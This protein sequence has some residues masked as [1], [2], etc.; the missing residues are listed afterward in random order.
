MRRIPLSR[1]LFALVDEEDYPALSKFNWYAQKS[2]NCFVAARSA[3]RPDRGLIYMH[4]EILKAPPEL[5]VDHRNGDG[6][7]NQRENLRLKTV[8]GN[9]QAF[10]RKAKGTTSRFRG[11]CWFKKSEKWHAQIRFQQKTYS[12]GFFEDE[13]SA[14]RAF[15]DGAEIL[16][17][18]KEALNVGVDW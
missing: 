15:N 3:L 10:V 6:L 12:L 8:A 17:F 18:S 1:G 13:V 2:R 9:K 5:Q 4:R 11:V 16:G 14:A 7:D